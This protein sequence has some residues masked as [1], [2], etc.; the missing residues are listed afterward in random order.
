MQESAILESN[1]GNY[2]K[3]KNQEFLLH[4]FNFLKIKN[5]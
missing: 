4:N 1:N 5:L 2:D 3:N